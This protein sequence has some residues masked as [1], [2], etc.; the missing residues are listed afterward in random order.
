MPL[1]DYICSKCGYTSEVFVNKVKDVVLC[2]K[3]QKPMVRQYPLSVVKIGSFPA[4][5]IHLTNVS[6]KG[7]TFYTKR[8]MVSYANKNKLELSALL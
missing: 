4:E 1:Y 2:T 6:A 8:E 3:C 7:K 5:G